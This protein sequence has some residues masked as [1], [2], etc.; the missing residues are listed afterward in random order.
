MKL[1]AADDRKHAWRVHEIARDFTLLD[2]W[3]FPI[4]ADPARHETF[5]DFARIVAA[6]GPA[7]GSA[8]TDWL[9][10]LRTKLGATFGW[11]R[12]NHALSIP[13]CR[14]TSLAAR[15]T[16]ADRA[17]NRAAELHPMWHPV[18]D[19]RVVYFFE[20]EALVELSNDTVHALLHLG[21]VDAPENASFKT[22]QMAIYI[23]SRGVM[24]KLYMGIIEPFR[25]VFVY[26]MWIRCITQAWNTKV[27]DRRG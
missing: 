25:F 7:T 24:T 4:R 6:N 12:R 8:I 26:P 11:D 10:A 20:D 1:T 9:L 13:G 19:L 27:R 17:R 2:V 15:L 3:G 16:D 23:K 14:E 18:V 5:D 21:W 22:P